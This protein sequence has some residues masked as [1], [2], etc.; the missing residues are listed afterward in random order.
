MTGHNPRSVPSAPVV[1]PPEPPSTALPACGA[2]LLLAGL[3][4]GAFSSLREERPAR[5]SADGDEPR[6]RVALI[7]SAREATIRLDGG[8]LIEPDEGPVSFLAEPDL[9]TVR[10]VG[11]GLAVTGSTLSVGYPGA[12]EV[13]LRPLEA[14]SPEPDFGLA[15]RRY[16]G[17]LRLIRLEA[18]RLRAVNEVGIEDYLA[19][20]IGH[21]MPLRWSDAALRAQVIAARTYAL[22]NRHPER[23]HDL[24][25]D[26]R[27]QVYAGLLR[28][29][30]RARRLVEETRGQV[31]TY[32]GELVN[33]YFHSTCGGDTVPARWIFPWVEED[34]LPLS[35]ASG[36]ACQASRFYR[37][38]ARVPATKVARL[39][40]SPPLASVRVEHWPRGLYVR[41]LVL[42]DRAGVERSVSGWD[43]RRL[44]GLRS[45]AFDAELDPAGQTLTL[46]G[47]GWGHGVGMCQFGAE[48]FARQGKSTRWILRHFYPGTERTTL[49]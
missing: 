49:Y 5:R 44:L 10:P 17:R 16:R 46:R 22:V 39:G 3:F 1:A 20:V 2:L 24:K 13:L 36:C 21:E 4:W 42:R 25:A 30:A 47:R 32:E 35:G 9:L 23:D 34:S 45:Y 7:E 26:T 37:W 48:G 14:R 40:L 15:G 43:A 41:R 19:G 8:W 27:S 18:E 6:V 38:T 11:G 12:R 29:D 31:V 33:T 28:E